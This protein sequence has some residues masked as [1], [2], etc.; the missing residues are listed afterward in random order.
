MRRNSD[1]KCRFYT[2]HSD[3]SPTNSER[4]KPKNH[5][6]PNV[7]K[8]CQTRETYRQIFILSVSPYNEMPIHTLRCLCIHWDAHAYIEVPTHTLRCLHIHW[9]AFTYIKMPM[10]TLGCLHI[11]SDA[12]AYIEVPTHTLGCLHIH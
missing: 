4:M 9:D 8:N 7:F 6:L 11:H 5:G 2:L 1:K 12:H 10:H 3:T